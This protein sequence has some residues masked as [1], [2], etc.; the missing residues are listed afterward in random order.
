METCDF[1][2]I[3]AGIIGINIAQRLRERYPGAEI[4]VLE[5]EQVTGE[6]G[7]GRNSG[8]IHA[9]FYYTS[10]SLK[11]K[12]TREGN[13]ELTEYCQRKKLTINQCGKLVVAKDEEEDG[14]LDMLLN[15]GKENRVPLEMISEKEA[16]SIEPRVRTF[17]RAIWSPTTSTAKPLEVLSAMRSDAERSGIVFKT[18]CRFV[19]WNGDSVITDAGMIDAGYVVNAAGLYA[20][21]VAKKF[22]FSEDYCI[23][24]FKGLYLYAREKVQSLAT[25]IYP[26]PDLRNPF[27][28]VH[29]TVSADGRLK[30]G[31]TAIPA[32]WRE[33]Y[34][35]TQNFKLDEFVE[36]AF[37]ELGLMVS[38]DFDFRT[39]ALE[40]LRKYNRKYLVEKASS[41]LDGVIASDFRSWGRPGIRAQLMNKKTRKLEM[42]F[43]LEGNERS[44]HVLN[45]VSPGWTCSQPFSN[46]IADKIQ[47]NI[48]DS[49]K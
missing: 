2:V 37:R 30:V 22:G 49:P 48:G 34:S 21:R 33:Q 36:I 1:L 35:A 7:S 14:R 13:V 39:L 3:G 46:Y 5:K 43:V 9:G 8:V 41:L 6:H 25:N 4:V 29:F 47:F 40:E 45:A 15:R 32:F 31:P 38:A 42:D 19:D 18:G 27:L 26:V 24:P 12:F 20:D 11:A 23:L 44:F 28:G 10:D 17:D 16:K